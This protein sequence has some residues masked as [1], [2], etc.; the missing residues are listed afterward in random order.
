MRTSLSMSAERSCVV[1]VNG[2]WVDGQVVAMARG[3][4]VMRGD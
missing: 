3:V 2:G 1:I 4:R